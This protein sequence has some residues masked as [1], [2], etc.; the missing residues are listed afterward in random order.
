MKMVRRHDCRLFLCDGKMEK[1]EPILKRLEKTAKQYTNIAPENGQFLSILIRVIQAQHVLEVGTSNGYSAIWIASALRQT[2]GQL[3]TLESDCK[4]AAEAQ[5]HL[6]E[7]G[8]ADTVEIRV[9]DAIDEIPLCESTFDLVFLDAEKNE[10]LRYLQLVLPKIRSGGLV[11]ADDTV[12][13]RDEMLDYVE[14]VFNTPL[15]NSVDIPLDDG[16]ILSY[17]TEV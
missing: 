16:I 5:A 14:Y 12:T 13:M 11:V 2:G 17:K 8:L 6:N 3:I 7:A 10:Y 1:Y 4:R 9:G 15:L